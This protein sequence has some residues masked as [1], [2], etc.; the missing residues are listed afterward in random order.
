MFSDAP[1]GDR[2]GGEQGALGGV[3]AAADGDDEKKNG[4]KDEED[5]VS[6]EF[7]RMRFD[8]S[9]DCGDEGGE[10]ADGTE[11][12]GDVGNKEKFA[13]SGELGGARK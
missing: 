5:E 3:L 13:A 10:E 7:F 4:W 9:G 12:A 11:Q 2:T 8:V 1:D 6:V